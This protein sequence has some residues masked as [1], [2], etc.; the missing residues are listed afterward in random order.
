MTDDRPDGTVL[1]GD[2]GG[3]VGEGLGWDDVTDI[4]DLADRVRDR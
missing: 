3:L 1:A 2:G 4:D